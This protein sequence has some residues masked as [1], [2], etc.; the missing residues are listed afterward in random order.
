M[1]ASVYRVKVPFL[2]FF[3]PNVK[4][5]M[6]VVL[7]MHLKHSTDYIDSK[8]IYIWVHGSNSLGGFFVAEI[9]FL[10]FLPYT[11]KGGG[12]AK[13]DPAHITLGVKLYMHTKF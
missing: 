6:G 4:I 3:K 1:Y 5:V 9:L 2:A 12:V 8:Y 7:Y 10:A 13:W 11:V